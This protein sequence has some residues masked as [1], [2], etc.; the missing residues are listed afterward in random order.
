MDSNGTMT[1][2]DGTITIK[3]FGQ[4]GDDALD[5]NTDIVINGGNIVK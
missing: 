2:N 1:I 3:S 5:C 4:H